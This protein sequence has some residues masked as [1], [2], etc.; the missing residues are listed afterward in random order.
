MPVRVG[1]AGP[2]PV[3]VGIKLLPQQPDFAGALGQQILARET[4]GY[5]ESLC[6]LP[7]QHDVAGMLHDGFPHH[8]HVLDI[9][10]SAHRTSTPRGSVHA[11]GVQFH[12]S[13]L[14]GQAA[15]TDGIVLTR[16]ATS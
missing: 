15:E 8:R 3:A 7:D 16:A 13:F 11:T 4:H 10:H 5:G 14:I 2:P 12:N 1:H 6:A 9:A